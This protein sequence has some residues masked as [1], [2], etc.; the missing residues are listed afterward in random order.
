MFFVA[1]AVFNGVGYQFIQDEVDFRYGF[2]G[3]GPFMFQGF[4]LIKQ[5]VQFRQVIV[6]PKTNLHIL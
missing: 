1:V 2:L 6:Y 4:E 3:Q 5:S